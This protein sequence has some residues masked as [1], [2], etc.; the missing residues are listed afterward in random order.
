MHGGIIKRAF[1]RLVKDHNVVGSL[2]P[3]SCVSEVL[4]PLSGCL[5]DYLE[6]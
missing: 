5:D 2:R 3:S 6:E 4:G 1:K